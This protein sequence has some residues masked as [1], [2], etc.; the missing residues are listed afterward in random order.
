[1]LSRMF[2]RRCRG[3]EAI[4]YTVVLPASAIP[5]WPT[6]VILPADPIWKLDYAASVRCLVR[7]GV[8]TP[9]ASLFLHA[10]RVVAPSAE[11]VDRAR[12]TAT[13]CCDSSLR[14]WARSWTAYS[15]P[16]YGHLPIERGR[17]SRARCVSYHDRDDE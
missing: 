5:G 8:D 14:T 12:R 17:P 7:D 1:M 13:S 16:F 6:D 11:G 10:T 2:D 15:T 4:G 9:L 3:H